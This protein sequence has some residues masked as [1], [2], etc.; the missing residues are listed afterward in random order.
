M[1]QRSRCSSA[2]KRARIGSPAAAEW[3]HRRLRR[4]RQQALSEIGIG[5]EGEQK[6]VPPLVSQNA[7]ASKCQRKLLPEEVEHLKVPGRELTRRNGGQEPG[8]LRRYR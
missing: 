5:V 7:D 3:M 4:L 2:V 8:R 6:Q 1:P